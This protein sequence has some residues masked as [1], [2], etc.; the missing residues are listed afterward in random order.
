MDQRREEQTI[1]TDKMKEV[2]KSF[3]PAFLY[4]L[5]L[6]SVLLV[7]YGREC[8][9]EIQ[10]CR[11]SSEQIHKNLGQGCCRGPLERATRS[12][13]RGN[14]EKVVEANVGK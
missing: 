5:K 2:E 12:G 13:I 14:G 8:G 4:L 7:R 6:H 10:P 9:V 1:E 3:P 11:T